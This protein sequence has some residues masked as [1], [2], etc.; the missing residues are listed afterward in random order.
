MNT[1]NAKSF[2]S[3]MFAALGPGWDAAVVN[4]DEEY[5][6]I[7]QGNRRLANRDSSYWLGGSTTLND[8]AGLSR[9]S[10]PLGGNFGDFGNFGGSSPLEFPYTT[11][12]TTDQYST[13]KA[14][15]SLILFTKMP[16]LNSLIFTFVFY[17]PFNIDGA[18][19][20]FGHLN[21][22]IFVAVKSILRL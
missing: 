21:K 16:G 7:F 12:F 8:N 22:D 13:D 14:S 2:L 5:F 4:S 10:N 6:D 1:A 9:S 19:L 18:A 17:K 11:V 3:L 20:N 15:K